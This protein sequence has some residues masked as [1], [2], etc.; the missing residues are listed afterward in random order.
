MGWR[1]KKKKRSSENVTIDSKTD[2]LVAM[3]YTHGNRNEYASANNHN[4]PAGLYVFCCAELIAPHVTLFYT[5]FA[6]NYG[7]ALGQIQWLIF[8]LDFSLHSSSSVVL[9]IHF[10]PCSLSIYFPQ[11]IFIRPLIFCRQTVSHGNSLATDNA[12]SMQ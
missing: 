7:E 5:I 10:R 12:T 9:I 2:C 3:I 11:F 6:S 4:Q 1:K 8:F